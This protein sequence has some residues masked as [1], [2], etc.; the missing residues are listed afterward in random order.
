MLRVDMTLDPPGVSSYF[1]ARDRGTDKPSIDICDIAVDAEGGVLLADAR[2][3]RIL[4]LLP[5]G[6]LTELPTAVRAP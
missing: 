5:D 4:R 2:G 1:D 3:A 6:N